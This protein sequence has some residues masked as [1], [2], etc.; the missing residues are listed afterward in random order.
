MRRS[1]GY[2]HGVELAVGTMNFG[3][4]TSVAESTRI[5]ERALERGLTLFDTANVYNQ[6]ESERILGRA[7][8]RRRG[9]VRIATKV[10]FDRVDGRAEGL[11]A[12]AIARALDA[13][14]QRLGTDWVDVYYLHA[15]DS[16]TPIEETLDAIGAQL[17]TGRIRA[18]GVS[19]YAAWQVLEIFQL[20]AERGL[21]RPVL[22][23]VIYNL[24]VRQLEIEYFRFA[25]RYRLH[26]TIYNPLAGGLLS[27]KAGTR[28]ES[29]P[30]YQR[31]YLTERFF[32]LV[33][34]YRQVAADDGLALVELAYAWV[35]GRPGVDSILVGPAD[36]AQ[37]DAAIDGCSRQLAPSTRGRIDE[38]Y[39]AF[40]G[41]D[42]CYAR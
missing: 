17:A 40:Q 18:F 4:R 15:P 14:L 33:E 38:I 25:A 11:G 41:T 37:L 10:G 30:M 24:L 39:R 31:R 19:N 2:T 22:S 12:A 23:Q 8:G 26:T 13:S 6:G 32:A 28:F 21:P 34:A 20:C 1:N 7:L 42:A 35:A 29:N 9:G 36:M 5:V 16:A 3:K 27:G